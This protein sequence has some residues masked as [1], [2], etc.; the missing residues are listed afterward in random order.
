MEEIIAKYREYVDQFE[1]DDFRINHKWYHSLRV[2]ERMQM[3]SKYLKQNSNDYFL[4]SII[5]LF[6]DYGRFYQLNKYNT[7]EDKLFDHG[8][9]GA[10]QLIKKQQIKNFVDLDL[11]EQVIYDAIINHNKYSIQP[12]LDK[13]NL[14]FTKMIRDADKL[15]ILESVVIEFIKFNDDDS[16]ITDAVKKCFDNHQLLSSNLKVTNND[17]IISFLCFVFDLEF[18]FSYNYLYEHKIFANIYEKLKN[19]DK[20]KHYFEE[21]DKYLQT[22]I[23]E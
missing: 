7:Y 8:D 16:E 21:I 6:H 2:M 5:G 3:L 9:Y 11:E 1:E 19:K 15:D 23:G 18:S 12:N 13:R 14:L 17:N 4:A 20:F 22:K 10:Y